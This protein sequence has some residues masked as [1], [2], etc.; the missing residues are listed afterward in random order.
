MEIGAGGRGKFRRD[1]NPPGSGLVAI[2]NQFEKK[3]DEKKDNQDIMKGRLQRYFFKIKSTLNTPLYCIPLAAV[4]IVIV[5][6]VVS[7][8]IFNKHLSMNN[9]TFLRINAVGQSRFEPKYYSDFRNKDGLYV[10]EIDVDKGVTKEYLMKETYMRMTLPGTETDDG[11]HGDYGYHPDGTPSWTPTPLKR[12]PQTKE[13]LEE[14]W[15]FYAFNSTLADS[16]P[17]RRPAPDARHFM[18]KRGYDIKSLPSAS[19]GIVFHNEN[20]GALLRSVVSV[21]DRTPA[22]LLREIILVDDNS[23]IEDHP[24]LGQQLD[25]IIATYPKVRLRRMASRQG[26]M[27]ARIR[28]A[29]WM[30]GDVS[31]FLDSHIEVSK[32]WLEPLVE[33]IHKSPKTVLVPKIVGLNGETMEWQDGGISAITFSWSL[34]QVHQD[35]SSKMNNYESPAMAGGLFAINRYWFM[36]VLG[37]YDTGLK[38]YGGEEFELGFKTWMCGGR[39]E[40]VPCSRIAHIFRLPTYWVGQVYKVPGGDITRNKRRV[41]EVWMDDYKEVVAH[42]MPF[43]SNEYT[44]GDVEREKKIRETC[45]DGKPSKSFQWYLETVATSVWRPNLDDLQGLGPIMNLYDPVCLDTM[46]TETNF[47]VYGCH[48]GGGTQSW[49]ASDGALRSAA[50]GFKN[51][52]SCDHNF[53]SNANDDDTHKI[54]EYKMS[55]CQDVRKKAWTFTAH[56]LPSLP[57]RDNYTEEGGQYYFKQ[58]IIPNNEVRQIINSSH[59]C[60]S[61]IYESG[62]KLANK[63]CNLADPSQFWVFNAQRR[64]IKN[65]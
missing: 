15:A 11:L 54:V 53:K 64:D 38:L 39:L 37:G 25:D 63:E 3:D 19:V 31:V 13:D 46:Q 58:Y 30:R 14:A 17:L 28:A 1:D 47:G 34:G 6:L 49:W 26:L 55:S 10:E 24:W 65:D 44:I 52:A 61:V 45:L 35:G 56:S 20:M 57:F 33:T 59:E 36:D 9:L 18:C 5:S 8:P 7:L 22:L 16:L 43:S 23:D 2:T 12:T 51:C 50:A 42:V 62:P 21:L 40:V 29:E 4:L 27:M 41:A 60:L 32:E 48:D